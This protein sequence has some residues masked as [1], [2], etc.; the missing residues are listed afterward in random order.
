[1]AW[2]DPSDVFTTHIPVMKEVGM[3]LGAVMDRPL[4]NSRCRT[5]VYNMFPSSN[6]FNTGV[7]LIIPNLTT[8]SLLSTAINTLEHDS[9]AD[10]EQGLINAFFKDR[11]V[12]E[13]PIPYNAFT[14]L[15]VCEAHTWVK[16]EKR[17]EIKL[18]HFTANKPWTYSIAKYWHSP[19]QLLSCWF[20][21]M[22][23]MC[24][25]WDMIEE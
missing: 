6:L 24:M 2:R 9:L 15:R 1:M 21:A 20:W 23:D 4:E 12:Y 22:E 19:I 8:Y 13:L 11:G 17:E 10:A 25:L 18:V 3:Q 16:Y 7:L 5:R 14:I